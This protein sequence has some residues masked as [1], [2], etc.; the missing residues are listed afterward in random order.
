MRLQTFAQRFWRWYERYYLLNLSVATVLFLL[1]AFHLYWLFTDV[2]LERLLGQSYF[3]FP[4][5]LWPIYVLIDYTEIPAIITT[6]AVYLHSLGKRNTL[7]AWLALFALNIQWLHLFWITDEIVVEN[8]RGAALVG[9]PAWLAWIA[10]LI[11]YLEVPVMVDTVRRLIREIRELRMGG[12]V[13]LW[14]DHWQEEGDAAY[15]YRKLAADERDQERARLYRQLAEVEDQHVERWAKIL[16]GSGTKVG[17]HRASL[18]VRLLSAAGR[19]IGWQLPATLLL[20]E[21][22]REMEGYLQAAGIYTLP[23]AVEAA[24]TLAKES[25]EHAQQLSDLLGIAAEPWHRTEAVQALE[26]SVSSAAM[27]LMISLG[28]ITALGGAGASTGTLRAAGS[29]AVLAV[30][31]ALAAMKYVTAR[32]ERD[33]VA[34]ELAMER[35]ELRLMPDLEEKELALVYRSRGLDVEE[36]RKT[37]KAI[38]RNPERALAEKL[39][40]ELG[41]AVTLVSPTRAGWTAG[42]SAF[43]GA[44]IPVVPFVAARS[45]AAFLLSLT[46]GGL[47]G[48]AIGVI[49]SVLAGGS[50]VRH[51]AQMVMIAA[52]I[53]V[54]GFL[55]GRWVLP[56]L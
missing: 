4:R 52:G 46:F 31:C 50:A 36:A 32:G 21:E 26:E 10:I 33:R 9:L 48:I 39:Q 1:Q 13:Q 24:K 2:I 49:R 44:S 28:L 7:Q 29:A 3:L 30:A 8:L 47:A 11:D 15:V 35:E 45:E 22:R 54:V 43:L 41:G 38:M 56:A 34:R 42:L 25:A 14:K 37:A 17:G 55:A 53:A 20:A 40:S 16:R 18:R 5:E 51:A 12:Q 6:S 19:L 23:D 27:A